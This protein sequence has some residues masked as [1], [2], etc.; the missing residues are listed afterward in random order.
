MLW[1][2]AYAVPD[3]SLDVEG[4]LPITVLRLGTMNSLSFVG[5]TLKFSG[6][7]RT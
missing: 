5:F 1:W 7:L 2:A 6:N 3:E 4:Q